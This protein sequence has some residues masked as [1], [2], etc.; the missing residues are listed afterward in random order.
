MRTSKANSDA[1]PDGEFE[2]TEHGRLLSEAW[3]LIADAHGGDWIRA[4]DEWQVAATR[5]RAEWIAYTRK[6][7]R[8]ALGNC[9]MCG[10]SDQVSTTCPTCSARSPNVLRELLRMKPTPIA[11]LQSAPL[12]GLVVSHPTRGRGLV[13]ASNLSEKFTVLFV[14]GEQASYCLGSSE[15]RKAVGNGEKES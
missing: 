10:S 6:T 4:T 7:V 12:V 13:T 11:D 8:A 15:R 1:P 3:A 2:V 5:W 9:T 14:T